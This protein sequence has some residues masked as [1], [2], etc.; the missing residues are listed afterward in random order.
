MTHALF[1][2]S[3]NPLESG[4]KRGGGGGVWGEGGI[5][6]KYKAWVIQKETERMKISQN[7]ECKPQR[8]LPHLKKGPQISIFI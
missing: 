6:F 7:S 8:K 5:V 3:F 2:F 4:R 1:L